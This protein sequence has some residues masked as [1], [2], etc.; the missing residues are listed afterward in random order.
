MEWVALLLIAAGAIGFLI[1]ANNKKAE[2]RRQVEARASRAEHLARKYA[3]SPFINDILRGT[4][5]QGMTEEQ[6]VDSWGPP[7]AK[8]RRVLK[9]KV[10]DTLKYA[11]T[12]SRSFRQQVKI[13]N[14]F[15]VGW[16]ER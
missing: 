13:E 15:V 2:E 11:Q 10:V 16:S 12:G 6:V 4:I 9:T 7:A 8:D 3:N 5:R 14:G 1:Q